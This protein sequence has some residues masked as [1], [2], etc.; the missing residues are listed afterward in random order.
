MSLVADILQTCGNSPTPWHPGEWVRARPEPL[1]DVLFCLDALCDARAL[2]LVSS[3]SNTPDAYT[4][5]P[6]GTKLASDPDAIARFVKDEGLDLAAVATPR[7]RTIRK[8]LAGWPKLRVHRTLFWLNFVVFGLGLLLTAQKGLAGKFLLPIA[9]RGGAPVLDLPEGV[10]VVLVQTGAMTADS[11]LRGEWWRLLACG[12]VHISIIHLL[13]NMSALR[14]LGIDSEWLWGPRRYLVLYLLSILGG[15]CAALLQL[16]SLR[17]LHIPFAGA[18]G[19]LCGLLAAKIVWIVLNRTYIPRRQVRRQLRGLIISGGII[20]VLSLIPIVSGWSHLGGAIVGLV[21]A[22]LLHVQR[23][24]SPGAAKLAVVGLFAVPVVCLVG[25]NQ[26]MKRDPGWRKLR[27]DFERRQT[28]ETKAEL[29]RL[30]NETL[31][32]EKQWKE[33]VLDRHP[34]RRDEAAVG[35]A[36][37]QISEQIPRLR[38]AEQ[39]L[40]DLGPFESRPHEEFRLSGQELFGRWADSLERM[41]ACL[42]EKVPWDAANPKEFEL[43]KV[44]QRW[45][46]AYRAVR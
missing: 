24:G 18:S 16:G 7:G 8:I 19:G 1:E 43:A 5:T 45:I 11:T 30:Y 32:L 35:K 3:G 39:R 36:I 9:M 14:V 33:T 17:A 21:A 15:S 31:D 44:V 29:H 40:A 42:E 34:A 22:L 27:E 23:F 4:L 20:V 37:E 25:L 6:Y 10:R 41:R 26:R 28:I 13:M 12:F 2:K 38:E 46:D